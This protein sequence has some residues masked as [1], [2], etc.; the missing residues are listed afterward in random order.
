MV[1]AEH[2][3]TQEPDVQELVGLLFAKNLA[4]SLLKCDTME[5]LH[6][7][8]ARLQFK[9]LDSNKNTHTAVGWQ[10]QGGDGEEPGSRFLWLGFRKD[11]GFGSV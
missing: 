6:S 9:N 4:V 5:M 1:T 11:G 2:S 7:G 3:D 10:G 8:T